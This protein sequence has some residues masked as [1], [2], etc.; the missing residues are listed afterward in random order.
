M[1]ETASMNLEEASILFEKMIPRLLIAEHEAL[2][3]AGRFIRGASRGMLGSYQTG[4]GP[5]QDWAP[6]AEETH[7]RRVQLGF[8]PDDPLLRNTELRTA[9]DFTV[10][11]DTAYVGVPNKMVG[12]GSKRNPTRNIG[13]VAEDLELGTSKMRPRSFLGLALARHEKS[14]VALMVMRVIRVLM[15]AAI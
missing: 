14:V 15:G 12:D 1:D 10:V 3:E 7:R 11:G 5:F 9:I 4:V 13:M 6:L 8:P 2:T